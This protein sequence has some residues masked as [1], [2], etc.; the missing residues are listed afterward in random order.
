M[1]S[2]RIS[3]VSLTA[4]KNLTVKSLNMV[5]LIEKTWKKWKKSQIPTE[6]FCPARFLV[7][8]FG[9]SINVKYVESHNHPISF[10]NVR[11]HKVP[12]SVVLY[13]KTS[14]PLGMTPK[15]IKKSLQGNLGKLLMRDKDEDFLKRSI[16]S[17]C[18]MSNQFRQK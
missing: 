3:P 14:L 1:L 15:A 17:L 8:E 9:G 2:I 10:A 11:F 6:L 16:L 18:A 12:K 7:S 5:N 13:I 4:G